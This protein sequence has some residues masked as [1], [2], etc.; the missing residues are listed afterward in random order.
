MDFSGKG[1]TVIN[2]EVCPGCG[3]HS[4]AIASGTKFYYMTCDKC[5]LTKVFCK[6][7][8]QKES[9]FK[10]EQHGKS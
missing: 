10:K 5:Y 6:S 4:F 3:G 7:E 2:S 9:L 8:S 1:G